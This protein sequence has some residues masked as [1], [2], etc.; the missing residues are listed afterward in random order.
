[1][2]VGWIFIVFMIGILGGSVKIVIKNPLTKR[3]DEIVNI[4]IIK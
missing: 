2:V 4:N 1:M 3:D